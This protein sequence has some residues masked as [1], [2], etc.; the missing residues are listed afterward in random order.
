MNEADSMEA[1]A[2][3]SQVSELEA[4]LGK[5]RDDCAQALTSGASKKEMDWAIDRLDTILKLGR[6]VYTVRGGGR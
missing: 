5:F 6:S 2:L 3:R 1:E 4:G